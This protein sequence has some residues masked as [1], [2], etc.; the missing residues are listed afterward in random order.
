MAIQV[1]RPE[2]VE[3]ILTKYP[4]LDVALRAGIVSLKLVRDLLGIDRY[5]MQDI[6]KELIKAGAV[7]GTSSSCFRASPAMQE[8]L[9]ERNSNGDQ[10]Q[11]S[12]SSK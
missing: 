3:P 6:Y 5:L 11:E 10:D 1:F 9:K 2:A 7:V 12:D 8:Y 4:E